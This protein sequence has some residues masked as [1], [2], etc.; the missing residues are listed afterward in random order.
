MPPHV[1]PEGGQSRVAPVT[2][3]HNQNLA[4]LLG[5]AGMALSRKI[6]QPEFKGDWVEFSSDFEDYL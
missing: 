4:F 2:V 6:V 3:N 1:T 5:P